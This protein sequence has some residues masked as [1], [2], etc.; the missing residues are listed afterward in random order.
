M[1]HH[2]PEYH[3]GKK[4][5]ANFKVKVTVRAHMIKIWLFLIYYLNC[6]FLGN[7]TWSDDTSSEARVSCE[8][9]WIAVFRVKVTAKGQ[10]VDVCFVQMISS[11]SSN[12]LFPNLVLSCII[13]SRSVM[14]KDWFA[15]FRVKVTARAHMIKIWQFLLY[16]LNC[17]SFC[18]QTCFDSTLS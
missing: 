1:Q 11:E 15:I 9:N 2:E 14:Q 6:W 4:L 18:Y 16:L 13:M 8:K 12:I 3:T 7:K 17:W 10:N 5:F